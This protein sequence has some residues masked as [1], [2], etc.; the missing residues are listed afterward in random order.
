MRTP[1]GSSPLHT[2]AQLSR[3]L[4]S[5][6]LVPKGFSLTVTRFHCLRLRLSTFCTPVFG[7]MTGMRWPFP[8]SANVVFCLSRAHSPVR[9]SILRLATR[10]C[11]CGF[12]PSRSK[13]IA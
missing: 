4:S 10:M 5:M 6:S 9:G 11:A 2:S 7:S 1:S 12:L 3:M 13:W 8:S